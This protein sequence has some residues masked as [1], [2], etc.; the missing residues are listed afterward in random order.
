MDCV[1][2][3]GSILQLIKSS[4]KY[5]ILKRWGYIKHDSLF[6]FPDH[7][8]RS[9]CIKIFLNHSDVFVSY[10]DEAPWITITEHSEAMYYI[11]P[12]AENLFQSWL[13]AVY[14]TSKNYE[15]QTSR[16]ITKR[17]SY[18]SDEPVQNPLEQ[19]ILTSKGLNEKRKSS[20]EY[21]NNYHRDNKEV[22][23]KQP[24]NSVF[25]P[26]NKHLYDNLSM[27]HL[28]SDKNAKN[29]LRNRNSQLQYVPNE[30][31]PPLRP[32]RN[33]HVL[34]T[35]KEHSNMR[36]DEIL[37]TKALSN[38]KHRYPVTG[39]AKR[40]SIAASDLLGK[41][42]DDLILLLLQLNR[43]KANLKRWYEYFTY[44]IDQIRL[45]KGNT[46]EAKSEIDVVQSELND[47]I[48]Q[49]E[50][51]EPLIKFLDN[52]IRMGDVYGGDDVL[53]AS[54]YR[55]HLLP[56]HEIVPSKPSLEF[57]RDIEEREIATILNNSLRHS[58]HRQYTLPDE[59]NFN[60]S[61]TPIISSSPTVST[62][63][64]SPV[65]KSI[66]TK[67]DDMPEPEEIRLERKRLEKEL[68]NLENLCAPHQLIHRK[69]KDTQ[70]SI[71][72]TER[73][74][75]LLTEQQS[76]K[77]A[78]KA[79]SATL[80]RRL[81]PDGV[82]NRQSKS[83]NNSIRQKPLNS[84]CA[85]LYNE[86]YKRPN[87]SFDH[88]SH[89]S[90]HN[91]KYDYD[92][93]RGIT[94]NY[95]DDAAVA[96]DDDGQNVVKNGIKRFQSI[97]EDLNL[98]PRDSLFMQ[99]TMKPLQD[100]RHT[101]LNV[102]NPTN[103]MQKSSNRSRSYSDKPTSPTRIINNPLRKSF[104][105]PSRYS[106][107]DESESDDDVND[108][109]RKK[110]LGE[111]SSNKMTKVNEWH[112]NASKRKT[113]NPLK[114]S[115]NLDDIQFKPNIFFNEHSMYSAYKHRHF[116]Q[117]DQ[118]NMPQTK[119]NKKPFETDELF[120]DSIDDTK[121]SPI[122]QSITVG[123]NSSNKLSPSSLST[124]GQYPDAVYANI[125]QNYSG[126][127][128]PK[129]ELFNG[130]YQ[131]FDNLPIDSFNNPN[132][133]YTSKRDTIQ[134]NCSSIIEQNKIQPIKKYVLSELNTLSSKYKSNLGDSPRRSS[135]NQDNVN[136][137]GSLESM[138]TTQDPNTTDECLTT[139]LK[140]PSRRNF[141]KR[142]NNENEENNV[143]LRKKEDKINSLRKVLL[144]QSLTDSSIYN[145]NDDRLCNGNQLQETNLV[146]AERVRLMTI[147]EQ[148]AKEAANTIARLSTSNK[149]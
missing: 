97:P 137:A 40:M 16:Y 18:P 76:N 52:M 87:T 42:R 4:S 101:P 85:D 31:K 103:F 144:R 29:T 25:Q 141:D 139:T 43:E 1:V 80:L 10:H 55:R 109:I 71:R 44:Q 34:H 19:R 2:I 74:S 138:F 28:S 58:L 30:D 128:L 66:I 99:S 75:K 92:Q 83:V 132:S 95:N 13:T 118:F 115:Q 64:T 148:L 88:Y 78:S 124:C 108:G 6:I 121:L 73:N 102:N 36:D 22:R 23:I 70:K 15:S 5:C 35:V 65:N 91:N 142:N 89:K 24:L 116:N 72:L 110:P 17:Q 27:N 126:S 53:F 147:K 111:Y 140:S 45:V 26:I 20:P 125:S 145:Q 120:K 21:S 7:T 47:V 134:S 3:H 14:K 135:I 50:L 133:L 143:V 123:R 67:L 105:L 94:N 37:E 48:G 136:S 68:D 32:P 149:H 39:L 106:H 130:S 46:N 146:I 79:P 98:F 127:T 82:H 69:L 38:V 63:P 49:L 62:S 96:A 117:N 9:S 33:P 113:F 86:M 12:V 11:R 90:Y 84:D 119:F 51:S 122:Q 112:F 59:N 8:N 100:K 107:N 77:F 61:I 54:E 57:A 56:S 41:S 104:E 60:K 129:S 131:P 114:S 81:H 93:L